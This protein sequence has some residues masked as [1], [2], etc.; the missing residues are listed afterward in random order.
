MVCPSPGRAVRFPVASLP[1]TFP[2]DTLN[3]KPGR[4]GAFLI[5]KLQGRAQVKRERP[6]PRPLQAQR[7]QGRGCHDAPALRAPS[8]LARDL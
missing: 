8:A 3:F 1:L 5:Q 2:I 7:G 6:P 4:E